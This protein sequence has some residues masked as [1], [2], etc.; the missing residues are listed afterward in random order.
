MKSLPTFLKEILPTAV[1]QSTDSTT[2]RKLIVI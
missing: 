2:K 1:I